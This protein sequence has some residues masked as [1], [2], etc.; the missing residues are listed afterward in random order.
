MGYISAK[1]I[2]NRL[3]NAYSIES[4]SQQG[5]SFGFWD[6]VWKYVCGAYRIKALIRITYE[7]TI[8]RSLIIELTWL[9]YL[10]RIFRSKN[11][12][13]LMHSNCSSSWEDAKWSKYRIYSWLRSNSPILLIWMPPIRQEWRKILRRVSYLWEFPQFSNPNRI[14]LAE[15]S[16]C[17]YKEGLM[18]RFVEHLPSLLYDCLLR[19]VFSMSSQR[20]RYSYCF[21]WSFRS[22][23][24]KTSK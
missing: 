2:H 16:T 14:L 18:S 9:L 15:M 24:S 3:A 4:D 5:W 6:P 19:S 23:S 20:P 8:K 22:R 11:D 12:I 21:V 10:L 7:M 17:G 13:S 1:R